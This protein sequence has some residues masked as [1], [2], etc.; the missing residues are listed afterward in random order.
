MNIYLTT[1]IYYASGSP[2]L[3]HAYTTFLADCYKRY[4]Q[5]RGD[6]VL[7]A[8]GTDEH[9]Q[10]IERAAAKKHIP[11]QSFVDARSAEFR[12]L[13]S[14]LNVSID[15]FERTTETYH[16]GIVIQ[17]W[18]KLKDSGDIYLGEYSGLYCIECEQYFTTGTDCPVHRIPL[19]KLSESSWFFR[20]SRYQQQLID[21]L[22]SHPEFIV[23]AQRRN[24]VLSFLR[25]NEL[26]DLSISRS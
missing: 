25:G 1:P 8:S 17:F 26:R 15:L 14:D 16:K 4:R 3:G 6:T 24:E 13:W 19:E 22:E 18:E 21:H 5:L 7:L 23:P 2:H 11:I 12:Q 20:L 9:G 10:K